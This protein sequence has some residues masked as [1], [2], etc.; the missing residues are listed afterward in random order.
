MSRKILLV[1]GILSSLLYVGIDTLAALRYGHY[2]SYTTQAIS[3]LAAIGAP[4]RDLV[5]P[6]FLTYGVLLLAFG[7]G[8]WTYAVRKRALR[9]IGALL[10]A[11]AALGFVTPPM[12]LRGTSD[13]SGDLPHIVLMS[14]IVLFI[15]LAVGLG[16]SLYGTRWRLYSFATLLTIIVSG[17]WTG[18]EASRLAWQQPAPWLGVAE[19]INVGAYLLWIV[20]LAISLLRAKSAASALQSRRG[21]STSGSRTSGKTPHR[22]HAHQLRRPDMP[23]WRASGRSP[24]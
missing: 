12:N 19:R 18:F 2:H 3:E 7:V 5:E 20:I 16:A 6:L 8:I 11:I 23:V 14:V 24:W 15:L 10:I 13:V 9:V 22:P 17:A 4:T 1:C 21:L